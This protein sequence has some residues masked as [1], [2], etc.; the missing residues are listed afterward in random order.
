M[1]EGKKAAARSP[2]N[3]GAEGSPRSW[4]YSEWRAIQIKYLQ[5]VTVWEDEIKTVFQIVLFFG[6]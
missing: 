4:L 5:D 1:P 2:C 6:G 3:C